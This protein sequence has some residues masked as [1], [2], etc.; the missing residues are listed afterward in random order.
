[1]TALEEAMT[2]AVSAGKTPLLLDATAER[3][4]D[5]YFLYAP[6]T[7]VEAKRMVVD[8][9]MGGGKLDDARERLRGEV[10]PPIG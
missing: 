8:M 2:R 4:T 5:K 10:R 7:V 6:A 1:M 9:R 3:V